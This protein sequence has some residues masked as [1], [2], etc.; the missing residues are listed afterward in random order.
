MRLARVALLSL[1]CVLVAQIGGGATTRTGHGSTA[2]AVAYSWPRVRSAVRSQ[3]LVRFA[4]QSAD[5]SAPAP[6]PAAPTSITPND[7]QWPQQWG[8]AQVDAPQAWALA[9][10][11]RQVVVAVVDSGVDPTQADL[12]GALVPGADFADGSGSTDDQYG[13]GTMVAGVIAARGDNGQG[14]AGACWTCLIMPIKVLGADGTGTGS[15]IAAGIRYA[16]DNGAQ[17]IN[18][19]VI[20]NEADS[21]VESAI[22]YAE[23]RGVL[24]VAAAGNSGAADATYPA[25]YPGVVS[26][27]A[28]DQTGQLYPWSTRGTWV[29]LAA[30]GCDVTTALGGAYGAFCGTS[31]ASPLVAGIAAL[32]LSTANVSTADVAGALE[33]TASPLPGGVADG[34]IDALQALEQLLPQG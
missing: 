2:R 30:P 10:S 3:W 5:P 6:E 18:L 31:A 7:P 12:Q 28:T 24:V 32:A 17:V 20:L 16:A 11:R 21:D 33:R 19:S 15:S 1:C 14:V 29:T 9:P 26:V 13:H 25:S 22:A 4:R 8:L 23:S 27:A 34:R